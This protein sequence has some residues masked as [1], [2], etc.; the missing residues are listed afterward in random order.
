MT[1][2]LVLIAII[3]TSIP[4][5]A[6]TP[7]CPDGQVATAIAELDQFDEGRYWHVA[8]R[9]G[10]QK[11]VFG[12]PEWELN[13]IRRS[14]GLHSIYFLVGTP[15]CINGSYTADQAMNDMAVRSLSEINGVTYSTPTRE[16]FL[17]FIV[18]GLLSVE[19][20]DFR[21]ISEVDQLELASQ[22]FEQ[23]ELR[24]EILRRLKE[25]VELKSA[26]HLTIERAICEESTYSTCLKMIETGTGETRQRFRMRHALPIISL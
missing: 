25:R 21:S 19:P 18:D 6:A 23:R 11:T 1:H 13:A 9:L 8:V 4:A 26:G 24:P 22:L 16:E 14:L 20:V 15:L 17:D 7:T 10:N 2:F 3:V 12:M 5:L